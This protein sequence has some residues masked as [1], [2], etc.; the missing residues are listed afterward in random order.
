MDRINRRDFTITL[1]GSLGLL[2][3][4]SRLPFLKTSRTPQKYTYVRRN[5]YCLN[6]YSPEIVAYKKAIAVMRARPA[7]DPTSWQAQANIHGAFTP[8]P[9]HGIVNVC[10]PATTADFVAP[11]GMIASVCRHDQFFLAWHRMYLYYFE[12][13]VRAASGDPSFALPYWGYSPT[14]PHNLPAVFRTPN[15]PANALWTDQRDSLINAGN[16]IAPPSSVDASPALSQTAFFTFQSTLSGVPHGV[17]HTA[18]GDGCGWMSYFDTAGMDP[19]FW[20]HHAN[21]DR[22]WDDWIA[23]GAGRANP[24]SNTAWMSQ[25]FNFYDETGTTV[26]LRVDQILDAAAQLNYRYAPPTICP[27]RYRCFCIP[28][29]PWLL[30]TLLIARLDSIVQ[31][32]PLPGPYLA[33]QLPEP[34]PLGTSARETRLPLS[35]ETRRR[36]SALPHDSQAGSSFKLVL[37]DI[38]LVQRPGVAYEIYVNLPAGTKDTAYTSPHYIG[39]LDFFGSARPGAEPLRREFDLLHPYVR[40]QQMQRWRPD[41]L[42]VTFVPRALVQGRSVGKAIGQR[43]QA[44]IGRMSVVIQ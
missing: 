19:I 44:T 5:V 3:P 1:A 6:S 27:T 31:R 13:I 33:A 37:E 23:M 40:L 32:P 16:D 24:T 25:S 29:R 11:P 7:T 41:T 14:G 34:T 28:V 35:A 42:R 20:L 30:D 10:P 26:S 18:T 39:T 12:R 43:P 15:T 17:V 9:A 36:I 22:L 4:A 21:I 2:E 8:D 38:R